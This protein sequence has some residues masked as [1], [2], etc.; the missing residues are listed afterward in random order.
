[1]Q[2]FS[3]IILVLTG[4]DFRAFFITIALWFSYN[5]YMT[6]RIQSARSGSLTS[7]I[8]LYR[9]RWMYSA[10]QRL[11]QDR[12]IDTRVLE[13]FMQNSTFFA[14]TSIFIAAG[15]AS[16]M[17]G[18]EEFRAL[19]TSSAFFADYS[20]YFWEA[21]CVLLIAIFIYAFF[22]Y[23]WSLR[24]IH[25]ACV[26]ISTAPQISAK[27]KPLFLRKTAKHIATLIINGSKHHDAAVRSF[28]AGFI[29][30]SSFINIYLTMVLM[31]LNMCILHRR[32]F[33]SKTLKTLKYD[34]GVKFAEAIY[35]PQ[36]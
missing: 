3:S 9:V 22:K 35:A 33:Y 14:S 19:V 13:Y 16:I 5:I 29:F 20:P 18:R 11:P 7:W 24:Q 32:E 30:F 2:D 1:M 8:N 4:H 34:L 27:Q 6:Y 12:L 23:T 10:M 21:R 36:A 15:I 31:I 26:L 17:Q 25:Y 28:Y